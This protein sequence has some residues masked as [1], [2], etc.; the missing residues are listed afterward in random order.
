MCVRDN[1]HTGN[2]HHQLLSLD[3]RPDSETKTTNNLRREGAGGGGLWAGFEG[4]KSH[5][6]T[7]PPT[8]GPHTVALACRHQRLG[9]GV[10][11]TKVSKLSS[12][13]LENKNP[14]SIYW[15]SAAVGG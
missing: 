7:T 8:V 9:P 10:H 13:M 15:P 3:D 2:T 12:A 4:I 6:I 5:F 14:K 1:I 11:V